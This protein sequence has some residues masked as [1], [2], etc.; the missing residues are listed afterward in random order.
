GG[1]RGVETDADHV[2]D[3]GLF[4]NRHA[5]KTDVG[6]KAADMHV[7]IAFLHHLGGLL[8]RYRRRAFVVD[9][10][11]FDRAAVNAAGTVDAVD[12]HLQSDNYGL[13][14]G[15]AGAGQRLLRADPERLGGAERG[16]PRL[17][18]QHHGADRAA[19][20]TDQGSA[21]ELAAIP[22]VFSPF[23]GFPL[24][25]HWLFLPLGLGPG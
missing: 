14:A 17:R 21:R 4:P 22:D 3:L 11:Q 7:D 18:H 2:D 13:A 16:A 1:Q 25:A 9:N 8:P 20:P 23:L 5:S 15:G 10:D 19:T 24:L 6:Q 12:R